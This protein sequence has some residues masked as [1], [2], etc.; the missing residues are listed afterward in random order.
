M[1]SLLPSLLLSL[2]RTGCGVSDSLHSH[3]SSEVR[4]SKR[5]EYLHGNSFTHM[6]GIYQVQ[7]WAG[8]CLKNGKPMHGI[9]RRAGPQV[10][11]TRKDKPNASSFFGS[12]AWPWLVEIKG[13]PVWKAAQLLVLSLSR[14]ARVT[15]RNETRQKL[16]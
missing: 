10:L 1:T 14:Q 13:S 8:R 12:R 6:S 2:L 5:E 4:W 3:Q 9:M 16:L 11:Q 15:C 7:L